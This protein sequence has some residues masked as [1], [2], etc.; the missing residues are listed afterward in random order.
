MLIRQSFYLLYYA[1]NRGQNESYKKALLKGELDSNYIFLHFTLIGLEWDSITLFTKIN[2]F[3]LP[4]LT[5]QRHLNK[6]YM[7]FY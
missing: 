1:L 5:F 2:F 7:A 3:V 6:I 4:K